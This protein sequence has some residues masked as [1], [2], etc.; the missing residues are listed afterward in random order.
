MSQIVTSLTSPGTFAIRV[1]RGAGDART[2]QMLLGWGGSTRKLS[3]SILL[4]ATSS[5]RSEDVTLLACLLA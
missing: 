4:A 2:K 3:V 1:G 5:S